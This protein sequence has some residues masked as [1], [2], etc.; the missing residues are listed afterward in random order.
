[1]LDVQEDTILRFTRRNG[2]VWLSK[3]IQ[4]KRALQNK[5]LNSDEILSSDEA[6]SETS[7]KLGKVFTF[8]A[9]DVLDEGK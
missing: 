2:K 9:V 1:M 5:V 4:V 6:F 7:S 3:H 8:G